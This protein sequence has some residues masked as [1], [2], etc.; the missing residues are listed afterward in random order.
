MRTDFVRVDGRSLAP[1]SS[2]VRGT[3]VNLREWDCPLSQALL[4]ALCKMV[5]ASTALTCIIASLSLDQVTAPWPRKTRLV[6]Y[7][8]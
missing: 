6:L 8:S 2:C 4:E 3:S 1:Y 7:T 5:G